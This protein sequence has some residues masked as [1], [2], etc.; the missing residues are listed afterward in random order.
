MDFESYIKSELIVLI[1][2]LY[3]I[4]MALKKSWVADSRI[5]AILGIAAVILSAIWVVSSSDIIG[6]RAWMSAIFTAVTQGILLA[7]ASVYVNQLYV[8]NRKN[9]QEEQHGNYKT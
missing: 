9:R 4:G 2:V 8:Q 7:G 1:P 6:F 5:P 3:I